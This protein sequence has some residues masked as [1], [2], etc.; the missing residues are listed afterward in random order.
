MRQKGECTRNVAVKEE[1][2]KKKKRRNKRKN[3]LIPL[4]SPWRQQKRLHNI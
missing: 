4:L 1:E 2:W 3:K